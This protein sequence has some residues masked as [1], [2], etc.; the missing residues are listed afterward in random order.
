MLSQRRCPYTGVVNFFF[1]T[2]PHLVVGSII[3]GGQSGYHWRCYT[4][5]CAGVG[6][7]ADMKS[8]E[9]QVMEQCRRAASHDA[10]H[11][12]DAA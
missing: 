10:S 8:A 5:P 7:V 3:K 12:V 9:R 11:L 4:D 2:D 1:V 6:R